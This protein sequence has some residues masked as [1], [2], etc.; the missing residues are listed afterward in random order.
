LFIGIAVSMI[1][2]LYRA[3]RPRLA[4]LGR[5]PGTDHYVDASSHPSLERIP[6]L[7]I[8]RVESG[9]FFANAEYVRDE[10]RRLAEPGDVRAVVLDTE[11]TPAID[12]TAAQMIDELGDSLREQGKQLILARNIGQVREVLERAIPGAD[13]PVYPTVKE[14]VERFLAGADSAL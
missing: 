1:L 2:L 4:V 10:I 3:A 6:G 7:V 13:L 9:L 11:T 14:A 5:I 12:L 8:V